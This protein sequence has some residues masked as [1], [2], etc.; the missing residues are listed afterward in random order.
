VGC[1]GCGEEILMDTGDGEEV[2]DVG[3]SEGGLGVGIKSGV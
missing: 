2:W 3:Q 1:G